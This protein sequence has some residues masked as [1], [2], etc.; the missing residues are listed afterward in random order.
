MFT[1][2]TYLY[3]RNLIGLMTKVDD[4]KAEASVGAKQAFAEKR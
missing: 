3:K 1:I 4:I 2:L